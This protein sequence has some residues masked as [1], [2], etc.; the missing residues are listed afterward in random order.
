MVD[1]GR[2][3]ARALAWASALWLTAGVALAQEAFFADGYHGGVY[4]HYPKWVTEFVVSNLAAFPD[5]KVNLEIEPVTWDWARTNS[6]ESYAAFRELVNSDAGRKRIEFVNPAY[7]QPYLWNISGESIIR[8]FDY[9]LRKL[10]EHFPQAAFTTYSSEEPCFTSALPGILE[11]FGCRYAVLKNP[12]T[13]WGGYTRGHEG[14]W[15]NWVGPD[16]TR[17]PAIPRYAVESLKPDSAWETMATQNAPAYIRSALDAGI[18]RPVGMCL[19]DAGWR[20]GPWLRDRGDSY[21]PSSYVTWSDFIQTTVQARPQAPD[22]RLSQEDVQVGLMWGSQVMQEIARQVRSAETRVLTAER[23]AAMA[24]MAAA[25]DWPANSLDEAWRTLML[26]QHHDCWIVPYNGPR[27][28]TWADSVARWTAET[29]QRSDA[30]IA[31]SEA[32]LTSAISQAGA[33]HVRVFN[34]LG[35]ER[36]GLVSVHL[37][38]G[39]AK[40]RVFDSSGQEVVSQVVKSSGTNADTLLFRAFA[41]G[42]GYNTY[43]IEAGKGEITKS[44][45]EARLQSDGACR[46]ETDLY[47]L[48][49]DGSKGGSLRSWIARGLGGR[50]LVERTNAR[51]FNE[52]RGYFF[53][54][55]RFC[56][57]AE[58]PAAIRILE[59]GPLRVRL[60]ITGRI[61]AH[62]FTQTVTVAERDPRVDFS[63]KVH[64]Q[65]EPGIG[66]DYA[67][68]G[69]FRQNDNRKAFYDDR[70]KL[71]VSFPLNLAS[72][73]IY[74]NAP[75]D[76]TESGLASTVFTTWDDIRNNIVLNWVD[77]YDAAAGCGVALLSDHTTSYVQ[78]PD[79]PLGLTLQYS[80]VGLWG[81]SYR[82]AGP[83]QV[84]YSLIPHAGQWDKAGLWLADDEWNSP[85]LASSVYA[86]SA[87]STPSRS[88]L[89][90]SGTGFA[91]CAARFEGDDLNVRVFNAQG[92]AAPKQIAFGVSPQR[93]ERVRL[94]RELIGELPVVLNDAGR[95][96]VRL[97]IPRFGVS[98]LRLVGVVHP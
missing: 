48:V 79:L 76:V 22:W 82:M 83:T 52:M 36:S 27:N 34:T 30:I 53:E 86:A 2:R 32:A 31:Q 87:S 97:G 93:V 50:E 69:H 89:N 80:G 45:A 49:F 60:E 92:D 43:R 25:T 1:N 67:Q 63:L 77:E 81:R 6:P 33:S 85:L 17:M 28:Q 11:S 68:S 47:Q 90:L 21:R 12:N 8:Q 40:S 44:R 84:A 62:P 54:E 88:F 57:S 13:C 16:G 51:A 70:A 65:G 23:M 64:W 9:G 15:V 91:L 66:A 46:V 5:W 95:P 61:G 72:R 18:R 73:K 3:W 4:G 56:S 38:A 20:K 37:P 10:R 41:P 42:L 78:G 74:K 19:Q 7:A 29:R 94:N 35:H 71:L 55:G 59:N 58:S 26:A 14:E 24:R 98:T 96:S 39:T 75:F